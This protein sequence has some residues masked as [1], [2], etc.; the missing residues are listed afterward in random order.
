MAPL[1]N[2]IRL[3]P[4]H[5]YELPAHPA[6]DPLVKSDNPSPISAAERP[7]LITFVKEVLDQATAFVDDTL[8]KTFKEGS[9]KSSPPSK[10]Q[11]RLLSK[12]IEA[13]EIQSIPWTNS[14]VKRN[15][16]ANGK[17]PPEAWF[18]RRSHHANCKGEGS[19]DF[20][21]FDFGLRRD[22]S[23][24][25]QAYTPDVFDSYKILDWDDRIKEASDD[26]SS[27]DDYR[28][29]SMSVFEMCHELP[30]MLSNRVFSVLVVTAKRANQSFIVVQVP[31][32]VS[33][34]AA[35][36]IGLLSFE[37]ASAKGVYAGTLQ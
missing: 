9:L 5:I 3:L 7:N 8:P 32:D 37:G 1:G 25:E 35:V 23:K 16:S 13:A 29:V 14:T 6:L 30:A 10:A 12:E 27:L 31:V 17:K 15:W 19:A 24:H 18:A 4:L 20:D 2:L 22:H 36:C 28:D 21:E 34:L 11:V 33:N 26:V